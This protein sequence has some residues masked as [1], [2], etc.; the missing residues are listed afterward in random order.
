MY[1]LAWS[2]VSLVLPG[3]QRKYHPALDVG[4]DFF[5]WALSFT[6]G[7]I[8]LHWTLNDAYE[9]DFCTILTKEECEQAG[10]GLSGTEKAGAVLLLLTGSVLDTVFRAILG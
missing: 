10:D 8:L 1:T 5:G 3:C 4:L 9:L 7:G 6:T 2:V